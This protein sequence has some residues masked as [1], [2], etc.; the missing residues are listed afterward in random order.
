MRIKVFWGQDIHSIGFLRIVQ[1]PKERS[2]P[3]YTYCVRIAHALGT[4]CSKEISDQERD[5]QTLQLLL[6]LLCF[7]LLNITDPS[8]LQN[9][10]RGIEC[11]LESRHGLLVQLVVDY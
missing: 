11:S 7:T 4:F 3:Y 10:S 5:L 2:V 6:R 8:P 9:Y 1:L